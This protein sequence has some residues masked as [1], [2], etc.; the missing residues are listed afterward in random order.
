VTEP[1][2]VIA[3]IGDINVTSST[4]NTPAGVVPL[5]GSQWTAVDQWVTE[6]RTPQWAKIVAIAGICFTGFLSLL[7]LLVKEEIY[8]CSVSVSVMGGQFFYTTRMEVAT[9]AAVQEIY[10]RVNYVRS[11]ALI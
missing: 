8:R 11:L 5:R 3:Q 9:P 1:T 10:D 7:L 6:R 2:P 4:V